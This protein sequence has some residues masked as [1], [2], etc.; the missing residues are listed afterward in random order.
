MA[1][2]AS[3]KTEAPS[4]EVTPSPSLQAYEPSSEDI[5]AIVRQS[6]GGISRRMARL[7]LIQRQAEQK[8][9]N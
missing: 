1:K 6:H 4:L 7:I 2:K 5:T 3:T 8:T 9:A